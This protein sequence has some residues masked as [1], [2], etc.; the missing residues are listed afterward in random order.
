MSTDEATKREQWLRIRNSASLDYE[1]TMTTA[2]AMPASAAIKY[3][4]L[5]YRDLH[6]AD[7]ARRM[8]TTRLQE[9]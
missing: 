5:L 7:Q 8:A 3:A 1:T 9:G 4:D 2:R 6:M